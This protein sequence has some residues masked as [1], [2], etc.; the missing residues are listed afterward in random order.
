IASNVSTKIV[1]SLKELSEKK[2]FMIDKILA[3][4][5][6][7]EQ[8]QYLVE[9][10][11]YLEHESSWEPGQNIDCSD[12]NEEYIESQETAREKDEPKEDSGKADSRH[13][14]KREESKSK[15]KQEKFQD[16]EP[17]IIDARKHNRELIFLVKWKNSDKTDFVPAKE[18]NV[19]WP[20][21]VIHFYEKR[22]M[23]ES[24]SEPEDPRAG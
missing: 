24:G 17:E 23:W 3:K 12:L 10:K 22:L 5:V 13:R 1:K 2:A 14:G 8:E 11:D 4:R 18:A 9:W 19:K 20:Q 16:L 15:S 6:L 7:K 21:L